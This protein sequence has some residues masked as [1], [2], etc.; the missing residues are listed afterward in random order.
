MLII[1]VHSFNPNGSGQSDHV[2]CSE[3][4]YHQSGNFHDKDL[5]FFRMKETR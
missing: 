3:T 2:E 4:T 5:L 1:E